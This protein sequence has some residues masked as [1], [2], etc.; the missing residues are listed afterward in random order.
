MKEIFKE[1]SKEKVSRVEDEI[2]ENWKKM[3]ILDKCIEGRTKDFVFYD[4]PATANGMPGLHHMVAKFLKDAFCKYHTMKGERVLRKI[5]WD[6]HG[7]PVE[8]QV[9]KKL[10][11][12]DKTDIEKFGIKEFNEECRKTVWENEKAFADLT[13]KM[14]QFIDLENRY[15]TYDNNYIETEWWILKK[16]FDEGLF[17]EGAKILPYCTRC[18]TGLA[19]HEVAQGYKEISVDT[20]IVPMKKKDE[21]NTYFLVW[22]TTPWTLIANVALCVNP[23]EEYI[24]ASS[25]GYNFIVAKKLAN[26]VLGDDYEI[27]ETYKGSDLEYTEYEQLLPFLSVDKH[28]FYVTCDNY[29]TMEDGTGIVHLAPAFGADDANVGKKYGLPYLNPVGEDGCYTDGPWK[30][31]RVFDADEVVI[32]YLKENDKLFKKQRMVHNYPHCW[33]C[34]TPL[35]YYSKPSFYLEVTKIKDKIIE[36]NKTVHWFPEY[37]GEKRF[38]NWLENLNDWAI[39]RSRYWGTPLPLWRCSCGHDEMIGSRKELTE[40]AIENIDESIEL[41]RPYVD[42]VHIKCPECGGVMTRVKDVIDC[43]FDSGSMPFA[44]YHYPFE[45]KELWKTQFP[46]DFIAEGIDQT[47]GWFYS[48]MVISVFVT[49][50]SPYKNVLVNELLLDKYGKKMHKS[51]GNSVEPFS[52]IEEYG[53]DTIRWYL[54]YVSPVWTPIK[55]DEDGLKEVYSKFFN[56]LKNTY[57]FFALYA[58]TDEVDARKLKVKYDDLEEIDKWLLSKYNK[59]VKYTTDAYEEYDLNKV[60]RSI[61]DFV[62]E[63]LSNWYIRRNRRR[64]WAHDL[65]TSKKAVYK[66]TYDVL[67]GL[68]KLIAP[69]VPFISEEIYTALTNQESVHL[70]KFPKCDD[71]LI[72]EKI[73][74]KMD[75]VRDL[76][77]LGRNVREEAKIKVRQPISEAILDGKNKNIIGDLTELIKE[78]LNVKEIKFA[79]DLSIYMNYEVKPNFKVCGPLLGSSI[80]SFQG[81][82]KNFNYGDIKNLEEGNEVKINLDGKEITITYDMLDVRITSKE[83]FNSTHEGNNF[84]VLNTTLNKDLINEG[85]ARELISK[86][87]QLRKNKDF[88]IVDRI[89]IYYSHNDEIEEAIEEYR[90][91]IMKDT[92]AE[93]IDERNDLTEEFNINGIEVKL[94]V[95]RR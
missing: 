82:V 61:T 66:T 79:D 75:L 31:M 83:G 65:D 48:L 11:F 58:N 52:L 49:G 7:L 38:G 21:E 70:A 89:N 22:T 8:V 5:G 12:K 9:E 55:F 27:L 30:G 46:A 56:T 32:K 18:G 86:I 91:M 45:N 16:F 69:V 17:Y 94:D 2:N 35:L 67:V 84:I 33:R 41:H 73:E 10:G 44:Q 81:Y 29:V 50:K 60:V 92:L 78:E 43:W 68:T 85:I 77:S 25:Q 47:R 6:T 72:D 51:K 3:D 34:D 93:Q 76:I 19:S 88:N 40:K 59:L 14:G 20:V 24:K 1:L 63:D 62:S 57:N 90:D 39:S 64:F 15:I 42:D 37:V 23:N 26:K 4:G 80:K 53:A 74:E 28:A 13:T 95:A 87:Q 71:K 36:A 54:P